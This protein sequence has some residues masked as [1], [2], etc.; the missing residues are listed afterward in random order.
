VFV[1]RDTLRFVILRHFLQRIFGWRSSGL[2][3][4]AQ[5]APPG[6]AHTSSHFAILVCRAKPLSGLQNAQ[7]RKPQASNQSS[8]RDNHS[9]FFCKNMVAW[10]Q[11]VSKRAERQFLEQPH[12]MKAVR[13]CYQSNQPDNISA[14]KRRKE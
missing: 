8:M 10:R 11:A 4:E 7:V 6:E 14:L 13:W 3:W 12:V 2:T 5:L 9:K 1:P